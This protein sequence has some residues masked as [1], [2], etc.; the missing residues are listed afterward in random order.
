MSWG[1]AWAVVSYLLTDSAASHWCF[2]VSFYA[3][4][5]LIYAFMAKDTPR[6]EV[7]VATTRKGVAARGRRFLR[8]V[9]FRS[10]SQ[11]PAVG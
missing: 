1:W 10:V 3:A 2:F 11:P 8:P 7:P 4:F 6:G 9:V 5:V